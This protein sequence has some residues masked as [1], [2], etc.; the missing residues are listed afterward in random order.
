MK[1]DFILILV[2]SIVELFFV[3][4]LHLLLHLTLHLLLYISR[5]F[6]KVKKPES[7]HYD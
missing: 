6:L 4:L 3:L 5:Q 7:E 1:F 2:A